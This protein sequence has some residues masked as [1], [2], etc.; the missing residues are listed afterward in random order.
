MN[1]EP[2]RADEFGFAC[3]RT[4]EAFE[5]ASDFVAPADCWGDV[6]AATGP[7]SLALSTIAFR[8]TYA[9]G[10]F[11]FLWASSESGERA[12]ALVELLVPTGR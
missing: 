9:N 8:K 1:G 10:P 6:S 7:L 5:S 11:S 12:S 3:L 4:K 2:Y